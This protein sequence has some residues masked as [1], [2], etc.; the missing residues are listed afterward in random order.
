LGS[1]RVGRAMRL[2]GA[3]WRSGCSDILVLLLRLS[4]VVQWMAVRYDRSDRDEELEVL[5]TIWPGRVGVSGN[6][7]ALAVACFPL[8]DCLWAIEIWD[9]RPPR[10]E[11]LGSLIDNDT[12]RC[13]VLVEDSLVPDPASSC[14]VFAIPELWPETSEFGPNRDVLLPEFPLSETGPDAPPGDSNR[15]LERRCGQTVSGKFG[16]RVATSVVLLR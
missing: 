7:C 5:A 10:F 1:T 13:R 12:A 2:P 9:F 14:A 15:R 6:A 8:R 16:K 4:D 3:L 11:V